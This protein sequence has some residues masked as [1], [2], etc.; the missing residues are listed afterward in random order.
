MRRGGA[1]KMTLDKLCSKSAWKPEKKKR[2]VLK[3]KYILKNFSWFLI[4][5]A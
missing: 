1:Q 5:P 2:S 4:R 3:K